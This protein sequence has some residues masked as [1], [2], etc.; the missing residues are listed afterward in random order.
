MHA[1]SVGVA[2]SVGVVR[3]LK[4][5]REELGK[6]RD[7]GKGKRNV[8]RGEKEELGEREGRREGGERETLGMGRKKS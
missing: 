7:G 4:E 5:G 6:G 8:G 2:S 3:T 1:V